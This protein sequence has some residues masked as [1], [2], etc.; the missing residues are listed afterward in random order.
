MKKIL[1]QVLAGL[2][3]IV[4][5]G[6][7]SSDEPEYR[8][9][10]SIV[11]T[12]EGQMEQL[13]PQAQAAFLAETATM[14]EASLNVEAIGQLVA[15]ATYF[16]TAY[17]TLQ[18]PGSWRKAGLEIL[19]NI[20]SGIDIEDFFPANPASWL[21][22]M[23]SGASRADAI[24]FTRASFN[25]IN[26]YT[27]ADLSGVYEPGSGEWVKTG[28]SKDIEF[29]FAGAEGAP[30]S[31]IVSASEKTFVYSF[32]EEQWKGN[33]V[34]Y[35]ATVLNI[36]TQVEAV[37][38][39]AGNTVARSRVEFNVDKK[40][41]G[42]MDIKAEV[43]ASAAGMEA[44]ADLSV[45]NRRIEARY[46]LNSMGKMLSNGVAEANGDHLTDLMYIVSLKK[47][48][49]ALLL[50][51]NASACVDILGRVQINTSS[52]PTDKFFGLHF[53]LDNLSGM[54]E[55]EAKKEIDRTA[56]ILDSNTGTYLRYNGTATVQARIKWGSKTDG[57]DGLWIC[58][59]SPLVS[60]PADGTVIPVT[61][62]VE[63]LIGSL[64]PGTGSAA[65]ERAPF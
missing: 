8:E 3:A 58:T 39:V 33:D 51:S 35:T 55:D 27:F 65:S 57:K 2:L 7:C 32:N 21:S 30:R 17:G 64:V 28:D 1:F 61:T 44:D 41:D 52:R 50:I 4:S 59:L 63:S 24:A 5:F 53:I 46:T 37:Y 34:Y 38:Q 14:A 29:R 43:T 16:K 13:S 23:T 56:E 42:T 25:I 62:L 40:D 45:T 10:D 22:E 48:E 19:E 60:F 47:P 49:E 31:F 12:G 20:G 11:P 15:E 18:A 36:P 6:S 9:P 54:S 26:S